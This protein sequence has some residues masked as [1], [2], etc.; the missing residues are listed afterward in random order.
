M[1]TDSSHSDDVRYVKSTTSSTNSYMIKN[2][3]EKY[4]LDQNG[5]ISQEEMDIIERVIELESRKAKEADRDRR[6]D[7]QRK[8]AWY[9][10]FGM[11]LYPISI[12][13]A[14]FAGLD[15]AADL[16]SGVAH[17]YVVAVAGLVAAFFGAQAYVN[18]EIKDTRY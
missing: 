16:L 10:L 5:K 11:L 13:I 15:R 18:K 3:I 17:T 2:L 12:V 1:N 7:T 6:E 4:D 8:M 9:A 14:D